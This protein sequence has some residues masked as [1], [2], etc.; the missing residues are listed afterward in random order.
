MQWM[1]DTTAELLM[2]LFFL[3]SSGQL[4]RKLYNNMRREAACLRIQ[5]DLRMYIARNSYRRVRSSAVTIQSGLRG[6]AA[7]NELH[8]KRQTRAAVVIQVD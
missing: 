5:K 1:P 7:R 6:M 2:Y 8:S 4:A 3:F